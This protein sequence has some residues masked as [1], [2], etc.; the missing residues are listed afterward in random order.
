MRKQ[1]AALL[2]AALL[3]AAGGCGNKTE[4]LVEP[5]VESVTEPEDNA[6]S[7]EDGSGE[8]AG[9]E[10]AGENDSDSENPGKEAAG[11]NDSGNENPDEGQNTPA[12]EDSFEGVVREINEK[13][14]LVV[15]SKIFTEEVDGGMVA[16]EVI[17]IDGSEDEELITV[18]FTENTTFKIKTVK[19]GGE[20]VTEKEG[21][22]SDIRKE[23][24]LE[25]KGK[26]DA[27]GEEFLADE[28]VIYEFI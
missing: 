17:A 18:Y 10:A 15:V 28:T 11:E 25:F 7:T 1:K 2:L 6:G 9:K 5:V 16:A 12:G 8:E 13:D 19:N 27:K 4:Q 14:N 24:I 23:S 21:A 3:L 20:E 26:M 22:F